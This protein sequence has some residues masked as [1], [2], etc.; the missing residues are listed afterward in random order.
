MNI[1]KT[2]FYILILEWINGLQ[3]R[4]LGYASYENTV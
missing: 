3:S 4:L 1:V 2:N